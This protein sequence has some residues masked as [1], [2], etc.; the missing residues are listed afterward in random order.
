LVL[1]G[2]TLSA[3]EALRLG[4]VTEV[5]D[6]VDF[7]RAVDAWAR[8]LA[9]GPTAAIGMAKRLLSRGM[10][11]DLESQLRSEREMQLACGQ[12]AD[13]REGLE[14]FFEKRQPRFT[15]R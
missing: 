3:D 1:T 10:T 2:E 9:A 11:A 8:R 13:F 7:E 14:A 5:V 15:G 6:D 12:S 4:L